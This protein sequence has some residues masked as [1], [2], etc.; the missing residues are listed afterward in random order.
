MSSLI[1]SSASQPSAQLNLFNIKANKQVF[2]ISSCF[3]EIDKNII[4]QS[5]AINHTETNIVSYE[6][7]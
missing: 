4:K 6:S 2:D 5:T 1:S 3:E 7:I